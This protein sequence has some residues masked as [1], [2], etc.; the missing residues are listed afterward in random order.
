MI[1]PNI[2]VIYGNF[3]R[4]IFLPLTT[5]ISPCTEFVNYVRNGF[6]TPAPGWRI[7]AVSISSIGK[8]RE[9]IIPFDYPNFFFMFSKLFTH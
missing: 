8:D 2:S 3:L 5:D 7:T 1:E 9:G 4:G 6:I